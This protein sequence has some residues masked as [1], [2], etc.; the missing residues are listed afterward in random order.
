MRHRVLDST[1][2]R[3]TKRDPLGYVDSPST[4][5]YITFHTLGTSDPSGLS[6]SS[7]EL[8]IAAVAIIVS[9]LAADISAAC[10]TITVVTIP[11]PGG[12]AIAISCR[13][14]Q[15]IAWAI[16]AA[17]SVLS[18]PVLCRMLGFC[19]S[20]YE[21]PRDSTN[22]GPRPT[23]PISP[24]PD[25]K[26]PR[27][28]CGWPTETDYRIPPFSNT[29]DPLYNPGHQPAIPGIEHNPNDRFQDFSCNLCDIQLSRNLMICGLC[30]PTPGSQKTCE[31]AVNG[32]YKRCKSV[33]RKDGWL[34]PPSQN[35]TSTTPRSRI[36]AYAN[37]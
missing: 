15:A 17:G 37:N 18:A 20:T 22:P 1:L 5:A 3:W 33:C 35:P 13:V 27:E 7:C 14:F 36:R 28:G 29:T 30:S 16:A 32:H 9:Y 4:Y 12:V 6:P 2:G 19:D 25:F 21:P 34:T 23:L 26:K 8:C 24:I 31:E 11:L 10:N